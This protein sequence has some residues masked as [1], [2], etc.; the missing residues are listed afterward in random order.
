MEAGHTVADQVW[1]SKV[2][3]VTVYAATK[4]DKD[5]RAPTAGQV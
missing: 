5:N 1:R 4:K 2:S 3:K